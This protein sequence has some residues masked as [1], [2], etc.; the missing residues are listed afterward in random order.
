MSRE[1]P[2]TRRKRLAALE[3]NMRRLIQSASTRRPTAEPSTASGAAARTESDPLSFQSLQKKLG[4]Q[5]PVMRSL[6]GSGEEV[7]HSDGPRALLSGPPLLSQQGWAEKQLS[8]DVPYQ[9][10]QQAVDRR[11]RAAIQAVTDPQRYVP[12]EAA[13]AMYTAEQAG[14]PVTAELK[15]SVHQTNRQ[16]VNE[17]LDISSAAT[18]AYLRG[19]M[20]RYDELIE[21]AN[22]ALNAGGVYSR[23]LQDLRN[24]GFYRGLQRDIDEMQQVRKDPEFDYYTAAGAG[25]E[26]PQGPTAREIK[27][28]V[29]YARESGLESMVDNGAGGV[30]ITYTG[31][32]P[33]YKYLS[34]DEYSVYNYY[35][36]RG[37]EKS[38][39]QYLDLLDRQLNQRSAEAL[40]EASEE[41]V[42]NHP[43]KSRVVRALSTATKPLALAAVAGQSLKNQ[44]NDTHEPV[45]PYQPLMSGVLTDRAY[46]EQM[47]KGKSETERFLLDLGFTAEDAA[48]LALTGPMGPALGAAATAG[49]TAQDIAARGGSTTQSLLGGAA[50]GAIDLAVGKLPGGS[51]KTQTVLERAGA[52]GAKGALSS[53]ARDLFDR[54][55]MGDRSAYE[56]YIHQLMK[57]EGLSKQEAQARAF[58]EFSIY[59]PAVDFFGNA[60]GSGAGC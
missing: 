37:D 16:K 52:E 9:T 35:L 23:R 44:W 25:I 54:A 20:D 14:S 1:N 48:L 33:K 4:E 41:D 28:P 13:Q 18:E 53:S 55:Y 51:A 10:V 39:Q 49:D 45:D 12:G 17:A 29:K 22:Q 34:D 24:T 60:F 58:W 47:S 11:R 32:D 31:A 36:G 19:D 50:G 8:S 26:V 46:R 21:Q 30:P 43:I 15:R 40:Y 38:A 7:L 42:K 5:H 56:Q 2:Q 57:S 6:T 27:N 3:E 59:E